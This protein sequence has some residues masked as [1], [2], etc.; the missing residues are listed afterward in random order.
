MLNVKYSILLAG[1]IGSVWVFADGSDKDPGKKMTSADFIKQNEDT[2]KE[3]CEEFMKGLNSQDHQKIRGDI[4][5]YYKQINELKEKVMSSQGE[6]VEG[7]AFKLASFL[8]IGRSGKTIRVPFQ[9]AT[10]SMV[11][12]SGFAK[13][14]EPAFTVDVAYGSLTRAPENSSPEYLTLTSNGYKLGFVFNHD[15][16]H[17][18]HRLKIRNLLI[19]YITHVR[20]AFEYFRNGT[21]GLLV[22]LRTSTSGIVGIPNDCVLKAA[23]PY[24]DLRDSLFIEPLSIRLDFDLPNYPNAIS[25][26]G[27]DWPK[28]LKTNEGKSIWDILLLEDEGDKPMPT[29]VKPE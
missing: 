10:S 1:I 8:E 25:R 13:A 22:D 26:E 15:S 21:E 17:D 6:S 28:N 2:E 14:F 4:S 18:Q 7:R 3:S 9:Q 27:I 23:R 19:N 16:S 5:R 11:D 24:I 29:S 12:A 20:S